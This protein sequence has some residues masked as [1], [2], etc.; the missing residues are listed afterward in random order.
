M[1]FLKEN[2]MS[3][4]MLVLMLGMALSLFDAHGAERDFATKSAST[5]QP[6]AD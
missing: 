4:L 6:S 2:T 5:V 3:V 1:G